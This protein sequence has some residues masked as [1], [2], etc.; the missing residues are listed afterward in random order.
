M[1]L[2]VDKTSA[3]KKENDNN[4]QCDAENAVLLLYDDAFFPCALS[5]HFSHTKAASVV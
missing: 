4:P 3:K 2:L 5:D 1:C